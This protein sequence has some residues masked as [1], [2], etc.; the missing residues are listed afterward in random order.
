MTD[1]TPTRKVTAGAA[2]GALATLI[3][4]YAPEFGIKVLPG[5]EAAFGVLCTLAF[6]YIVKE[7]A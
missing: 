2:G 7:D 6:A 5:A 1:W 4:L 3:A